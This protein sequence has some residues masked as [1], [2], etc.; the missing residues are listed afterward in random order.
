MA[1]L[2]DSWAVTQREVERWRRS[3]IYLV[4]MLL[5]PLL[6][7]AFFATLFHKGVAEGLP[8]AV[9]DE[10]HTSLSRSL[11][12]MLSATPLAEVV[13]EPTS[14]MEAKRLMREG[15]IMAFVV[16]PDQ[17]EAAI[18]AN[19][20][21]A[22]HNFISGANLSINGLL[23]KDIQVAAMTFIAGVEF[24]RLTQEG[25]PEQMALAEVM[26]IRLDTHTL[27]NPYLNYGYY[28]SPSFMPMM[29]LIFVVLATIFSIGVELKEGSAR[30]W[31]TTARGNIEVALAGKLLPQTLLFSLVALVM[32]AVI[33]G[34]VATPF[35][36]SVGLIIVATLLLVASYQA[37]AIVIIA[38]VANL[39]LS[40]SLGGGYSV[41]AFTFSGATFPVMA[42]WK[43]LQWLSRLFPFTYYTE[44]SIDQLLRGTPALYSLPY[45]AAMALFLLLPLLA[46]RRLKRVCNQPKFWGKS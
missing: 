4:L 24:Q 27:F 23:A 1:S 42:M 29:L 45:L 32:L 46:L 19:R 20:Q 9:V 25:L 41:L 40:L 5:L 2:R 37:I 7:F 14:V 21:T 11:V 30:E 3:P 44:I 17:F 33:S 16:V 6:S 22:I 31:L 8:I 10:D 13:Y 39:R 43:P 36:G 12:E 34:V 35:Q 15:Q 38:L 26:P 18:F 28:L